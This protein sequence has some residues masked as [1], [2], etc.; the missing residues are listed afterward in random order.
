M[1]VSKAY[2]KQHNISEAKN[3]DLQILCKK[4]TIPAKYHDQYANMP[5]YSV[6]RDQF[7]RNKQ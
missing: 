1:I 2:K 4:M 6:I 5:Y 7:G 3:R